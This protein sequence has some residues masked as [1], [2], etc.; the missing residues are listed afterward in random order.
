MLEEVKVFGG[1]V[2][3]WSYLIYNWLFCTK[4]GCMMH[5]VRM[6]YLTGL[7]ARLEPKVLDTEVY[8][9]LLSRSGQQMLR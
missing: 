8:Y 3:P 2:L 4:L 9:G 1:G 6:M 7:D 5:F